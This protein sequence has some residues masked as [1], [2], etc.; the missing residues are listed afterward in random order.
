MQRKAYI[1][2][3]GTELSTGDSRDRNGPYF[4]QA[5]KN[6]NFHI[7]GLGILPDEPTLLSK[8]LHS[9]L[10]DPELDLLL[11]SGGLGPTADDHSIDVLAEL[12]KQEIIEDQEALKALERISKKDA[13]TLPLD[14]ARRQVRVLRG[15]KVMRNEVGLA[16]GFILEWKGKREENHCLLAAFPGVP[17]EMQVMFEKKFLKILEKQFPYFGIGKEKLEQKKIFYFYG[18]GESSFQDRFSEILSQ[19]KKKD[20]DWGISAEIGRLKVFCKMEQKEEL[21][22]LEGSI[23]KAFGESFLEEEL[24]EALHKFCIQNTLKIGTAESCTGGLIAKLI[25]DRSGSSAYFQ[26]SIIS[27]SDEVKETQLGLS[28]QLLEEKGAVSKECV[29]AMAEGAL[30]NLK[31]DFS[32]AVSGIAGPTGGK[33]EKPVGT[34]YLGL[35]SKEGRRESHKLY[36]P[37]Q[38]EGVRQYSAQMALFYFYKFLKAEKSLSQKI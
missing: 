6:H 19:H 12:F 30:W 36:S 7:L 11:L 31:L 34:V 28:R 27:Y 32:L 18:L 5:L 26:G 20:L 38:R 25:T 14:S 24:C 2:S 3:T 4:A 33:Q 10:E 22:Q 17:R 35:A 37:L 13:M 29:I 16:P 15:A 21:M 9:L 23:K 8:T 1:L